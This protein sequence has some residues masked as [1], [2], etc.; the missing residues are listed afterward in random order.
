MRGFALSLVALLSVAGPAPAEGFVLRTTTQMLAQP[1]AFIFEGQG[2]VTSLLGAGTD[3]HTYQPTRSDVRSMVEADAV[4]YH[5]LL[6]EAQLLDLM[7]QLEQRLPA[8]A[9]EAYQPADDLLRDGGLPD[10]HTWH[11]P[12]LW[13]ETVV[14]LSRALDEQTDLD[15]SEERVAMLREAALQTDAWIDAVFAD[16]DPEQRTVVSAHDAFQ[17]YGERY[18]V[19]FEPLLGLSTAS[20][21]K[22]ARLNELVDLIKEQNLSAVFSETTVENAGIAALREGAARRGL[23]LRALPPLFSDAL[24]PAGEPGSTY[25]GMLIQNTINMAD[26]MSGQR[27]VPPASLLDFLGWNGLIS[28]TATE[29]IAQ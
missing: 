12:V 1:L 17:Y 10:P 2:E 29:A 5:G 13:I 15:L 7:R 6:F 16:I 28:P 20:E 4:T 18:S 25:F 23:A 22:L 19:R 21:T 27:P 26:A 24:A 8:L 14:G 9:A 11:N 3:P